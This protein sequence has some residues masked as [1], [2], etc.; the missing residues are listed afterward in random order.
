MESKGSSG[1][2]SVTS[3]LGGQSKSAAGRYPIG[4]LSE[5]VLAYWVLTWM[6][7]AAYIPRVNGRGAGAGLL[8]IVLGGLVGY[9]G[10]RA[11]Q[12]YALSRR[13]LALPVFVSTCPPGPVPSGLTAHPIVT[14]VDSIT[15]GYGATYKCLPSELRSILPEGAHLVHATDTSYPGD[16]ARLLHRPVLNYGVG[17]ETTI[18]GLP[19][20][21]RVLHAVHPSTVVLLEGFNDL[22]AGQMPSAVAGRLVRMA[23]LI[24][25]AGA[26]P[27]L[28]T[29]LPN[30]GPR[31]RP[32]AGRIGSLNTM[33]RRIGNRT[34]F[35]LVDSAA[36]FTA[37][38]PLA[39]FFRHDDGREDGLHP[40]DAGYRVLAVLVYQV[41]GHA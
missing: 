37:H 30:D 15:E 2:G 35:T 31:W 4:W 5:H 8:V 3:S 7:Q 25:Q 41:L 36:T 6:T 10:Y 22:S 16:L 24:R 40:N 12:S 17:R 32:L 27:V 29:V 34:H 20:L 9:A 38:K 21:K 11:I 26:R 28:L 39:A 33:L 1:T 23:T 14:F 13:G 18:D 19:R